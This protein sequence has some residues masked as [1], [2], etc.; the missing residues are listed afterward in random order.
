MRTKIMLFAVASPILFGAAVQL[1]AQTDACSPC[2]PAC[3]PITCRVLVP[4][5]VVE[6]QPKLVVRF[7]P[8]TRERLVT[9]YRDVP[10][11]KTIQEQYTVMVPQTLTRTIVE[12]VNQPTYG[13]IQLRTT[14]VTPKVQAKQATYTV[15]RYVPVQEQ[16]TVC[17]PVA[18][19]ATC[20]TAVPA[21]APLPA[22]TSAATPA[23]P[24]DPNAPPPPRTASSPPP[25]A[26]APG[27]ACDVG[28]NTCPQ[29]V[30]VT[31]WKPVCQQETV[32]YPLSQFPTNSRVDTVAFYE[33]KP[34]TRSHEESYVV[35]VPERRLRDRQIT[36]MRTMPEQQPEAYTVMVP[37]QE[38]IQVPKV[39]C[40]WV[41]KTVVVR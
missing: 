37:Y 23:A 22:N 15:T 4:Q 20:P 31:T 6:H 9:V 24:P 8:E 18:T 29:K 14:G 21:V 38:T 40:R 16:R 7:R 35:E 1:L 12:T 26:A 25:A 10:A 39:T 13:D 5:L 34:E 19:C 41:E 36:V 3:P 33:Y 30:C 2:Q 27:P 11:M 32:E 17:E 28:C